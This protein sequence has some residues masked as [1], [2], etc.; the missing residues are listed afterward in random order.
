MFVLL[1][2][3]SSKEE[4]NKERFSKQGLSLSN[5][6]NIGKYVGGHPKYDREVGGV[7]K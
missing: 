5:F 3:S 6:T 1:I 2:I 7:L 4:K